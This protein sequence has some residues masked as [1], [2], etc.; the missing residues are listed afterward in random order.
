MLFSATMT[1]TV[2][3]LIRVSLMKPIKIFINENIDV[4][5]DLKQEF[6]RIRDSSEL[7]KQAL[8]A[9]K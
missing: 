7:H 8:L 6:I 3:D 2:D 9:G 1:D 4:T 5:P